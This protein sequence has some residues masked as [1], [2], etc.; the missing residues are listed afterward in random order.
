[1]VQYKKLHTFSNVIS[2]FSLRSWTFNDGN[3]RSLISRLSKLDKSLFN[4]DVSKL[5]WDEYFEIHMIGIRVHI[6]K[7]PLETLPEARRHMKRF[8]ILI[9]LYHYDYILIFLHIFV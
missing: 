9:Y 4:F 6:L 7:D 2:Y 3:T 8:V 5:N 1:M